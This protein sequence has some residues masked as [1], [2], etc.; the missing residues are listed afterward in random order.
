MKVH[1]FWWL[2]SISA[3]S[4]VLHRIRSKICHKINLYA[5]AF[6]LLLV[7]PLGVGHIGG[8]ALTLEDAGIGSTFS[9]GS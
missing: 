3:V 7:L 5:T 1:L 8:C 2:Q 4:I 9:L 6:I